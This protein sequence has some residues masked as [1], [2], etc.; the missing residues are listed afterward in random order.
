MPNPSKILAHTWNKEE[1]IQAITLM[2]RQKAP[3]SNIQLALLCVKDSLRGG[4]TLFI[5]HFN[6]GCCGHCI[7]SNSQLGPVSPC[8][9]S[10]V[11]MVA[12]LLPRSA[13]FISVGTYLQ[14]ISLVASAIFLTLLATNTFHAFAGLVSQCSATMPSIQMVVELMG[15]RCRAPCRF[16]AMFA[17]I[18]PL[19]SSSLAIEMLLFDIRDFELADP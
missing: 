14:L 3:L 4:S 18:W 10:I 15:Q 5:W 6:F 19:T 1:D 13:K 16:F 9:L 2:V 11:A 17:A 8:P 12:P 7:S